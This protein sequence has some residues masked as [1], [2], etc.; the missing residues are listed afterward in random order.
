MKRVDLTWVVIVFTINMI[1]MIY[2][3][4]GYCDLREKTN[5]TLQEKEAYIA[6]LQ[7][8]VADRDAKILSMT[9]R[10]YQ[11]DLQIESLN[12]TIE[13][14]TFNR[15]IL[16]EKCMD[17]E[18][19]M[20]EAA[21]G[22]EDVVNA[23]DNYLSDTEKFLI[24]YEQGG[25]TVEEIGDWKCTAYCTEKRAHICGTGSGITASGEEVQANVSVAVNKSNLK[26]LPFGTH[27]YIE[28]VGE[29]V[30]MDTGS[31]VGMKQFD[32]AVDTHSH[33]LSW[34]GFGY[35]KV[36]ILK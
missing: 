21:A 15:D 29:R 18:T 32:C 27:I 14:L 3:L 5:K 17:L 2:I 23:Y 16:S 25:G 4:S 36:W 13:T 26:A 22:V 8:D 11:Y 9:N 33:A 10:A 12:D 28:G 35:H 24:Q 31:A 1:C 34:E 7:Q 6:Q 19:R 20:A 30:V